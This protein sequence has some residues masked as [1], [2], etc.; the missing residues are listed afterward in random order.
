MSAGVHAQTKRGSG[1]Y[2]HLRSELTRLLSQN[3]LD[4]HMVESTLS[5]AANGRT[6]ES[7]V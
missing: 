4:F 5:T 3:L 1:K 6:P 7:P 2:L